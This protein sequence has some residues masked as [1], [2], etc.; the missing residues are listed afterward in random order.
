MHKKRRP[1]DHGFNIW[2]SYSDMMAGVLL[3]FVLMNLCSN[4]K[5]PV[6]SIIE[7]SGAFEKT[8]SYAVWEM[9]INIVF[10]V[11]AILYMGICG[12]IL[13]S[14]AAL[15]YRGIMTIYYSNTK[16]LKRSQM[17]TYKVLLLNGAVFAGIMAVFFVDS[18][19]NIGF[20]KLLCLGIVHSIW[21]AGLYLLVN[22]VF[23]RAAFHTVFEFYREEKA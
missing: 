5:L 4:A 23:N 12:A 3:L 13:G 17:C 9:I 11:A 21:I 19:S 8:R 20:F 2:R 10:S 15:V 6:N 1:E 22:F 7:Y 16:I 18:F 14:V